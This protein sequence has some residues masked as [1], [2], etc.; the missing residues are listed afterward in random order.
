MILAIGNSGEYTF[1][2][3]QLLQEAFT[4]RGHKMVLF[5]QDKCLDGE[6]LSFEASGGR[7][8]YSVVINGESYDVN[9]FFAIYFMSPFLPR[10][11]I[12]LDPPEYRQLVYRQFRA[13][14]AGLQFMFRKKRWVNDPVAVQIAEN[15]P[16]QLSV[17]SQFFTI[18]ETLVTS[19]PDSVRRFYEEHSR[20]IVTK[21]LS[22]SPI[23][24]YVIYTNIVAEQHIQ[25]IDSVKMSPAIFQS[26]VEKE[27]ELRITVVGTRL[28]AAKLYSQE[29]SQTKVDW[30]RKPIGDDYVVRME[31]FN[32]S[33]EIEK[34]IFLFMRELGL[35]Y[36]CIDMA[37]TPRGEYV[38]FEVNPSG[39]W[40]FV[41]LR[42]GMPIAEAIADLL[43]G[44]NG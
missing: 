17:A 36:G 11:L 12:T 38:F 41:Q 30:R 4:T 20:L 39:Q 5:K 21:L 29:D 40:Y 7:I 43:I 16:Y 10:E 23:L 44:G 3:F 22:A 37:V 28:F 15:K 8:Q 34:S 31:P 14:R 18:P 6:Y 9:K 25:Q 24:N 42:T 13:L 35:R 2:A 33:P 1:G 32:L 26:C 27:F 19:N